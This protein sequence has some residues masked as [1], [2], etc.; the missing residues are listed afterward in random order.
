MDEKTDERT[1]YPDRRIGADGGTKFREGEG[2]G[3]KKERS[4]K[5]RRGRGR[6][7]EGRLSS[8]SRV[9]CLPSVAFL[10]RR[11]ATDLVAPALIAWIT[12]KRT[13]FR[14]SAAG[15]GGRRGRKSN[16]GKGGRQKR[17]SSTS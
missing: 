13:R 3:G 4:R 14:S 15:F 11:E 6:T 8:R 12:R 1:V 5:E 2:V 16:E 10:G 9:G 7:E 17:S